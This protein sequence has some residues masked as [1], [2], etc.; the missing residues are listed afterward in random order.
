VA[1]RGVWPSSSNGTGASGAA[2]A[3]TRRAAGSPRRYPVGADSRPE[4]CAPHLKGV[5]ARLFLMEPPLDPG[6]CPARIDDFRRWQ[7]GPLVERVFSLQ[8]ARKLL[9]R[10]GIQTGRT[11]KPMF[12]T[13]WRWG[14]ASWTYPVLI[15]G[16]FSWGLDSCRWNRAHGLLVAFL[17]PAVAMWLWTML[18]CW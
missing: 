13:M 1:R 5:W 6:S 11:E 16:P 14:T 9:G 18:A 4:C 3:V 12:T 7:Q 10:Y 15:V 17:V 2:P 8:V